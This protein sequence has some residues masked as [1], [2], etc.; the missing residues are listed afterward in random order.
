LIKRSAC[1]EYARRTILGSE[2]ERGRIRGAFDSLGLLLFEEESGAEANLKGDFRGGW[3][4]RLTV[5]A[6]SRLNFEGSGGNSSLERGWIAL[7]RLILQIF[8]NV[9]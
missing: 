4:A 6:C 1:A 3:F 2:E 5:V 7:K 8:N 9:L